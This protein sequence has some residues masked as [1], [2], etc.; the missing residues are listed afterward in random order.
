[1]TKRHRLPS[2]T[3]AA[4]LALVAASA[5]GG[6]FYDLATDPAGLGAN[7]VAYWRL[8][9]S[10]PTTAA[11]VTGNY[12]GTYM[13]FTSA[14]LGHAGAL[15]GD[16]DTAAR[17]QSADVQY[18]T[19]GDVIIDG[20]TSL[21]V[22]AWVKVMD[23]T[24]DSAFLVKGDFAA[25]QPV[26]FWRDETANNSGRKDTHSVMVSSP[27]R[28]YEGPTNASSDTNWHF[29][30]FTYTAN[31]ATGLRFYQDGTLVGTA[32]TT[33][34]TALANNA[35]ALTIGASI[36]G[37]KNPMEGYMDDMV[38]FGN[39]LSKADVRRLYLGGQGILEPL[40]SITTQV[41]DGRRTLTS[42]TLDRGSLG[43]QTVQATDLLPATIVHYNT[44]Q[45]A[46]LIDATGGGA[47]GAPNRKTWLSD[48]ALDTGIANVG[49]GAGLT[50]DPIFS[51]PGMGITFS[52]PLV[53]GPGPDVLFFE[54]DNGT[55]DPFVVSPLQYQGRLDLHPF[56]VAAADYAPL[57]EEVFDAFVYS[58]NQNV[59]S[60]AL[61][62]SLNFGT[63][64]QYTGFSYFAYALD[65]TNLGYAEGEAVSGLFLQSLDGANQFDPML[66]AAFA[67][68]F[69]PEPGTLAL[70]G[71]GLLALA[72]RRRRKAV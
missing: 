10:T 23:L 29:V 12:P 55:P 59:T 28:R 7:L 2:L 13:N 57:G 69:V 47:P 54:L 35:S 5:S 43:R 11:D 45:M 71:A 52:L 1:M 27:E 44:D 17:F 9:E 31:S 21:T 32:S 72:R 42:V 14:D 62:E 37:L 34:Q 36:I 20:R 66:I 25:D 22:G 68:E 65:L 53:N 8:G 40:E 67:N 24:K 39:A 51:D 19:F 48:L 64:N 16:A 60:L 46:A 38:V 26:I 41:V 15:V 3:L 30:L 70:L 33:G 49:T 4:A 63:V 18:I 58:A 56:S 50:R 6:V 61:L